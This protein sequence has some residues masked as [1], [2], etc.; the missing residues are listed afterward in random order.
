MARA[1][2]FHRC[3]STIGYALVE[4]Q[5]GR[6]AEVLAAGSVGLG[7]LAALHGRL[8]A[9][10][11]VPWG[12]AEEREGARVPQPGSDWTLRRPATRALLHPAA[13]A[14]LWE[15][16]RGRIH[17]EDLFVWLRADRILWSLGEPGH[18]RH[19]SVPRRGPLREAMDQLLR[20]AAVQSAPVA[21]ACDGDAPGAG[22]L[23]DELRRAGFAVRLSR[24]PPE[25][26]GADRAA[27]GAALGAADP[28]RPGVFPPRKARQPEPWFWTAT[29]VGAA[30]VC[31]AAGIGWL[32]A[33]ALE[34][35][36]VAASAAPAALA[37][38]PPPSAVPGEL[39]DLLQRRAALAHALAAVLRIAPA[40]RVEELEVLTAPG[41]PCA[42]VRM[43]LLA[44]GGDD[45][46]EPLDS[47][48]GLHLETRRLPDGSA[49]VR[50]SAEAPGLGS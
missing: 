32:R 35:H 45:E 7:E 14:A 3:G 43:R 11:A 15:W 6:P 49:V 34:R 33:K 24:R 39:A 47:P 20:D 19:G 8:G 28:L 10:R 1:L 26:R 29:M 22:V 18:G 50:G 46:M 31:G 5:A 30:A 38:P 25:E 12:L 36:A 21:L 16:D 17:G 27:A 4:V 42:H 23:E 41:S 9:E 2:G 13:A 44:P 48:P 40:G 37:L